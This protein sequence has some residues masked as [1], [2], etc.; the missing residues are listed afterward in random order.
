MIIMGQR[1]MIFY[2]LENLRKGLS[3]RDDKRKY[4]IGKIQY[5]LIKLLKTMLKYDC[6]NED[7]IR[8]YA[9]TGEYSENILDRIKK[10]MERAATEKDKKH[11]ERLLDHSVRAL[12][13]QQGFIKRSERFNFFELR[14]YPLKYENGQV[15]QK[16]VDVQLAVDLV[17]NAYKNNFD[18]AIICSGDVDLLESLKIVKSLGKRIILFSHSQLTSRNMLKEA[19]YFIDIQNLKEEDL[20]EISFK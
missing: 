9:Y 12:E 5:L 19:D 20:N 13:G 3:K 4:D 14:S 11:L 18:I 1:V 8:T 2:D 10:D 17:S 7:L 16:G 15:F 6:S